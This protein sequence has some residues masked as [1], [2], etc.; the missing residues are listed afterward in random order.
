MSQPRFLIIAEGA[1]GPETSKTANS[2]IRY[3]PDRIVGVLD[4][5]ARGRT[6]QDVLGFGGAIPVVPTMD[7]GLALRPSAVLIGIAPAGGRLPTEWRG[8]ILAALDRG[9]DIWSG[10]HT[11]LGDDQEFTARARAR[12]A[13]L[14]DL[15]RPPTVLPV[16]DGKARD[17]NALVVL[18]VGSDCNVGKMTAA[19][20]IRA[21]LEK[22]GVRTAFVAPGQTGIFIA[23][24]GVAVDAVP[25][26][27]VAG[28]VEELVLEAARDADIVLVEGQ[29]ALHH[30]AYSGVTLSLLHGACPDSLVLCHQVGRTHLRI[31]DAMPAPRI[32]S[33][34]ELVRDYERASGWLNPARVLA[35]ALNTMHL[36]ES[37]ARRA[38]EH[39][40]NLTGL[41]VTDPVRFGAEPLAVALLRRHEE[42]KRRAASA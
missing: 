12:G 35:V 21:F 14:L 4:S 29:G 17:V 22:R 19:L 36:E 26:D 11:Y 9:L 2:A 38:L 1:F 6:C 30:P 40:V 10:L 27:F 3:L 31:S 24:R 33:I 20:E 37:E 39:E 32:R 5:R 42:R 28:V 34:S 7:E 41:T 25:A 23:D 16:S 15:R 8:W 18:S 13:K